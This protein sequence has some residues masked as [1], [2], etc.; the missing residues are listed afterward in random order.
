MESGRERPQPRSLIKQVEQLV[1][2]IESDP[3]AGSVVTLATQVVLQFGPELGLTGGRVFRRDGSDYVLSATFPESNL[4]AEPIRVPDSYPPIERVRSRG[5]IFMGPG[6]PAIDPELEERLGASEFAAIAIHREEC[7][8]I[9]SFDVAPGSQG[10]DIRYSLSILRH[11]INHRLRETWLGNIFREARLIQTSILPRAAP[12]FGAFDIAGR[13]DPMEVVGGDFFDFLQLS[14]RILGLA[15]ADASGH[16][17]PAALQVRDIYMGLRMGMSREF[18]IL[19]TFERLNQIVSRGSLTSRFVSLFYGELED[20]GNLIFVNGGHP[21]PLHI[22]PDGEVRRLRRGGVVLGPIPDAVYERGF[23][24]LRPGDM[25]VLYSDGIAE[26]EGH[27]GKEL[28]EFGERRLIEA[29]IEHRDLP[30]RE[31]VDAIFSEVRRFD[32]TDQQQDD[33][34]LVIVK[35]PAGP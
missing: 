23:T 30:A 17:L 7:D 16:G 29:A 20:N 27:A 6:H 1:D 19:R 8:C 34:T 18:K 22:R 15:I 14:P 2:S 26:T 3:S 25:L 13:S 31:M 9:I 33:R 32:V 28:E 24:R 11:S 5:F 4:P 35:W 10:D 21:F 12:D